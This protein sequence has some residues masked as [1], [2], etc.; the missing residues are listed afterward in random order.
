MNVTVTPKHVLAPYDVVIGMGREW[1]VLAIGEG[2]IQLRC[3]ADGKI[4]WF[5]AP[6]N[7]RMADGREFMLGDRTDNPT[8]HAYEELV[9]QVPEQ[10]PDAYFHHVGGWELGAA[11]TRETSA[12]NL[13][14]RAFRLALLRQLDT[15]A[16]AVRQLT[17]VIE[18]KT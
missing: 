2:R 13:E 15:L 8:P 11:V 4:G 9:F 1:M 3:T 14:T 10:S 12:E 6:F 18:S 16:S 17:D 5:S 7:W